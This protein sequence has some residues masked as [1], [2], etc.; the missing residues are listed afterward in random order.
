ME[1]KRI[2]IVDDETAVRL[3][4][5][6]VLA[7][8]GYVIHTA[9]NGKEALAYMEQEEYDLIITDYN[10]PEMDGLELT[11]TVR[12]EYPSLPILAVSSAG[13]SDDFI[14]CGA[15]A[16]I[17]KPFHPTALQD[18]VKTILG[19]ESDCEPP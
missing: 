5:A 12:L 3:L 13:L 10:M 18:V 6:Q 14:S 16:C 19:P 1:K 7:R 17:S 2:L 4:L 9:E 8:D 15:T 11:K